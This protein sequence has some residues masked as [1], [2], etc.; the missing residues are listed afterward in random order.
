MKLYGLLRALLHVSISLDCYNVVPVSN[1]ICG[2]VAGLFALA[3][4]RLSGSGSIPA[5]MGKTYAN[6][7]HNLWVGCSIPAYMGKTLDSKKRQKFWQ[8]HI[9]IKKTLSLCH[10]LHLGACRHS[11]I[12]KGENI[13]RHRQGFNPVQVWRCGESSV[14]GMRQGKPRFI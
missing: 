9:S 8:F 10:P 6:P 13:P 3:R 5:Y 11:A 2:N 14:T 1:G 7:T 12:F 4:P